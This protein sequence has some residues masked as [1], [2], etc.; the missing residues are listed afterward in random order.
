MRVA[1]A[2]APRLLLL[3]E[4]MAGMGAAQASSRCAKRHTGLVRVIVFPPP[5]CVRPFLGDR[6]R[7]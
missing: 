3:D 7:P 4:P 2:T 6:P 1:L 5:S